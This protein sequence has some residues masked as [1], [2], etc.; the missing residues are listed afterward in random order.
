[1]TAKRALTVILIVA[2]VAGLIYVAFKLIPLAE[3]PPIHV[4]K[5]SIHVAILASN[6][7]EWVDEGNGSW[8]LK[9]GGKNAN[10]VYTLVLKA[11]S[12][13]CQPPSTAKRVEISYSDG[14]SITVR[15]SAKKTKVLFNPGNA[16]KQSDKLLVYGANDESREYVNEIKWHDTG[17]PTTCTFVANQFESL[18]LCSGACPSV[19]K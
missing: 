19:C 8:A 15:H 11:P 16:Q 17:Q 1:M 18:C 5:G 7:E 3:E 14:L 6:D 2:A 4:K 10:E 12:G 9:S 13:T